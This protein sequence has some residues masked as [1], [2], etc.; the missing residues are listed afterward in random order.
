LKASVQNIKRD[1][2]YSSSQE[3]QVD[4]PHTDYDNRSLISG[5][6][7]AWPLWKA[8]DTW[9]DPQNQWDERRVDLEQLLKQIELEKSRYIL[10]SKPT[11]IQ[12][13]G[14]GAGY[15]LNSNHIGPTS[16]DGHAAGP[17]VNVVVP[18]PYGAFKSVSG[19]QPIGTYLDAA[20]HA[21]QPESNPGPA[22]ERKSPK[23][24][25]SLTKRVLLTCFF[26]L[27]TAAVVMTFKSYNYVSA[28]ESRLPVLP[29][30]PASTLAQTTIIL[31]ADGSEIGTSFGERRT[32]IDLPEMSTFVV[33]A[34]VAAEDHRFHEHDGIDYRRIL[35]A[36]WK[37]VQGDPEGASTIPMQ[38]ARNYYPEIKQHSTLDRKIEELLLARK[39]DAKFTKDETIEWYLN[40][41]AFGHNSF[42]IQ[43]AAKRFYS[44]S[45]L[46]LSLAQ[47]ALLV[48]MLKGPSKYDPIS[49]SEDARRRRNVVL[50]R[51]AEL[52]Y[53]TNTLAREASIQPIDLNPSVFDPAES[54]APHFVDYVKKE[55]TR[56]ANRA[57]Y[58]LQRDG[59]VIHTSLDP[60]TQKMAVEA[61]DRQTQTLQNVITR[62]FGQP[63]SRANNR[64]WRDRRSV[65]EDLLRRTDAYSTLISAGRSD[66]D[67]LLSLRSDSNFINFVRREASQLQSGFVAMDPGSG[68]IKAWVGG[69]DYRN[70]QFDKVASARR[71]PGSVFKPIVYAKAIDRG[72]SPYYMVEDR[73]KTFVTNTRGERWTPTNSGGGASGRLVTLQQGLA[74]SKNTI[75]VHLISKLGPQ[76][77]IDLARDMG[78]KSPMLPVPSISLG[79]SETTLLEMVNAYATLADYG[80]RRNPTTIT[81]ISDRD[82]SV[83]ATFPSEPDRA[84]S[85]QTSY[86]ML[87]M[88]RQ[89]IDGGTGSFIRTRFGVRGDIAG[90]TGTTQNNADGWFIA[91]HP[92][93]VV[94]AW[95]GF[96]DQRITFQSDYW[97]QGGHNALLLVGDFLKN[98][99]SGPGP[100]LKRTRFTVP[101]G[102]KYPVKPNYS[103]GKEADA[104][105]SASDDSEMNNKPADQ[106]G[107]SKILPSGLRAPSG[108]VTRIRTLP[109]P[110]PKS[111]RPGS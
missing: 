64:F 45:A 50:G 77:V 7:R 31:A 49:R 78:I 35:G 91:M 28:I 23:S 27:V 86:T 71:Q 11:G 60:E 72:F 97:G 12:S 29:A 32:W 80:V 57:G 107:F 1:S 94:G 109:A 6:V 93:L 47:A 89:V 108:S 61:L 14:D 37:T 22:T 43:A 62:E 53:V 56:W 30:N 69:R 34:L 54:I 82:G 73:I 41:V 110:L 16:G 10:S 33:D 102:Y 39:I 65:E 21:P 66:H 52:G 44:K 59:L 15:T 85:S 81:S 48:G 76:A 36:F 46:E 100:L 63:G 26:L 58:D 101:S 96:N 106:V 90:K 9:T 95:V 2:P 3:L 17:R 18:D 103:F 83:I 4:L 75:S 38:L 98:A 99:T 13:S 88:M 42:G 105:F 51:M 70:D 92:D 67:A 84:L 68:Q 5:D 74:W 111:L 55:A 79:T 87:N 8:V 19:F 24:T 20:K 40:T 104:R 25:R